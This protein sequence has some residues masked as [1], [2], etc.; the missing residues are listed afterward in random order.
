[1]NCDAARR[2]GGVTSDPSGA[3][4][5]GLLTPT[6]EELRSYAEA[7]IQPLL[8]KAIEQHGELVKTYFERANY[9]HSHAV[10][11]ANS[12]FRALMLL[13]GGALVA[14]PTAVALFQA[15]PKS[16]KFQLL[17]AA[18][19]FVAGLVCVALAQAA[20]FLTMSRQQE[21]ENLTLE[22]RTNLAIL[23]TFQTTTFPPPTFIPD[24][25]SGAF[26][27]MFRRVIAETLQKP[28]A[29]IAS[30]VQAKINRA[31]VWQILALFLFCVSSLCFVAGCFFGAAAL[32]T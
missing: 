16:A 4:K 5:P 7:C 1:M 26:S 24:A 23:Q 8:G 20:A 18:A 22:R 14:I 12:A 17:V 9:Y 19:L 15:D 31:Y 6:L 2:N 21:A 13:N 10:A 27:E 29:E 25:S 32:F 11:F 30:K 3:S 28:I